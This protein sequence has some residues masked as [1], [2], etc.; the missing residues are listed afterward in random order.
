MEGSGEMRWAFRSTFSQ[1][2]W[3]QVLAIAATSLIMPVAIF[4]FLSRTV[5]TYQ[6]DMLRRHEQALLHGLSLAAPGANPALPAGLRALYGPGNGA[7]AFAVL[8][9]AGAPLIT[10]QR[11]NSALAPA[12]GRQDRPQ[13]FKRTIGAEVYSGAS[14]PESLAGRPIWIQVG[15]NLED[16]DVVL[17]D[18]LAHFL[19]EVGWLS[20]SLLLLLLIADV[21]IVRRALAPVRRASQL[22]GAITPSRI[23]VR[24]P[25]EGMP[26]EIAPMVRAVNEA[27]E[28]LE[29]GF[30]AQRDLTADVAHELRTP[31]T[32]MRMRI[33]A[34]AD[35]PLKAALHP[36]IDMMS[37][38]VSQLLAIA[39]LE[40][41]VVDPDDRADLRAVCLEA[42]EHL[43]PLAIM[44]GKRI[45][46]DAPGAVWVRGQ[47]D[48]LFQAVRN[49]VE[50]AIA[51]TP[52]GTAVGIEV[53]PE[54]RVRVL[55]RGPG[56]P[57]ELREQLFKRFWRRR[58]AASAAGAGA[59]LGLSI[60]S[61][62]A[63]SH[64]GTVVVEA[65]PGGGAVFVLSLPAPAAPLP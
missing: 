7:F 3:L 21:V 37:R 60:V 64:A 33:E 55:D 12:P 24:L 26:Q 32:V 16:P 40:S 65:R 23:D 52:A 11:D 34:M 10:S 15:Q 54:G 50:N 2:I 5:A 41:V 4:L 27:L 1:I 46:L 56:V 63:E 59:G 29:R 62:I 42:A 9:G 45:E 49:L 44:E 17:D 13:V 51:H 39:E 18:V 61:R 31:L 35:P 57:P 22:A 36:D 25:L 6:L 8:D 47:H 14:F 19:P 58:R 53:R 28:R 43:A 20:V 30:R 38:I 48:F